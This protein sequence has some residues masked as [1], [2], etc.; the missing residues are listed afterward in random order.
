MTRLSKKSAALA[1][2]VPAAAL[3]ALSTQT[4]TRGTTGDVL[5]SGPVEV[6]GGGAAPG[7]VGLAVVCVI[8]LLG[9]M[10]GGR[11]IR[12]ASAAVLVLSALGALVLTVLVAL[13]PR[14]VVAAAVS[15]ELARTTAPDAAGATTGLGWMAV[16]FAVLLLLGAA[17]AAGS[18]GAWSGLSG[19]YERDRPAS[20]PRGEVRTAWDELTDGGDP[21]LRDGSGRT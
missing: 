16:V 17:V 1:V 12:T 13:R 2:G 20:G 8:A 15:E 21:T 3:L 14:D 7:A 18:S 10:T 11:A 5:S 6:S 9:M 19:R 4:W